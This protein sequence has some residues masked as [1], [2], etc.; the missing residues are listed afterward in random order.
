MAPKVSRF[1]RRVARRRVVF[2]TLD[3]IHHI[4]TPIR[5][6]SLRLAREGRVGSRR[7]VARRLDS[8]RE[9]RA[10]RRERGSREIAVVAGVGPGFGSQRFQELRALARVVERPRAQDGFAGGG[11]GGAKVIASGGV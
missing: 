11:G 8:K 7:R 6:R 1:A 5:P 3:F 9:E 10:S 2:V 4:H